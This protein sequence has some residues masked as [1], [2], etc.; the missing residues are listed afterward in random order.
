M[1]LIILTKNSKNSDN[2]AYENGVENENHDYI[3]SYKESV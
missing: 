2:F 3:Y 1:S